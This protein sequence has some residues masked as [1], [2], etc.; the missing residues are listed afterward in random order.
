MFNI[1]KIVTNNIENVNFYNIYKRIPVIACG[2]ISCAMVIH[3][4]INSRVLLRKRSPNCMISLYTISLRTRSLV[5]L[6]KYI[7]VGLII[8][9]I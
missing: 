8:M 4:I 9:N 2:V 3:I 7:Y 6:I 5:I 1:C